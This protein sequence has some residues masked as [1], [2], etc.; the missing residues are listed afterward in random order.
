M[1]FVREEVYDAGRVLDP[2]RTMFRVW[3]GV[4]ERMASEKPGR[5]HERAFFQDFDHFLA[6]FRLG[7]SERAE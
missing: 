7:T 2:L 3:T 1:K 5:F 4:D 6:D